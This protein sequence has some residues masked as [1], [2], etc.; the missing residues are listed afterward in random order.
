M[1]TIFLYPLKV[2]ICSAIL[3]IYY[4]FALRNK[5]FH[6]YNRFY[7]LF[8][9][10]VSLLLPILKLNWFYIPVENNN[11]A[12]WLQ[13]ITISANDTQQG[14]AVKY[15][16]VETISISLFILLSLTFL[17]IFLL[18]II[19]I[20]SIKKNYSVQKMGD[21]DFIN[22]EIQQAPF[23]F[24][25]ML[26]WRNDISLDS[27]AGRQIFKHELSHI[28]EKHTWDK[29]FVQS[30]NCFYWYNPFFYFMRKELFLV[31]E[32]I[33]DER[34]V[35]DEGTAAFAEMLLQANF[36]PN[37]FSP[38]QSFFY[39][40][41]KRR[42]I[43]LTTS[44]NPRYSYLRRLLALP[45]LA[46]IVLLFAFYTNKND[47]TA[48]TSAKVKTA[49]A[50]ITDTIPVYGSY[51]GKK[52]YG[53]KVLTAQSQVE[54]KFQDNTTKILSME[55]AKKLD[56]KIPPPPPPPPPSA[57]N[58]ITIT[59]DTLHFDGDSK[60]TVTLDNK[61]E[62]KGDFH[63]LYVLN[64]KIIS[65]EEM[66]NST[67][68]INSINVIKGDAATDKYGDNGKNGVIEI[69]AVNES[70]NAALSA[71]TVTNG[72]A[73]DQYDKEFTKAQIEPK[74]PGG[75][76]AWI[77]YLQRNLN[78]EVPYKAHAPNGTYTVVVSFLVD[79]EGTISEVKAL[80]DPGYGTAEEAVR[81]IKAGPMWTPAVQNGRNVIYRQKQSITFLVGN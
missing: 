41:I 46:T 60:S 61:I 77:K 11:A 36:Y 66:K 43:M 23:T 30:I 18:R 3:F 49:L 79:K 54:L 58:S 33:A 45:L 16:N 62:A 27:Q 67:L 15:L 55:E 80:N 70:V 68:H 19:K 63:P 14:F 78:S 28:N 53:V 65:E 6:Y 59:A 2:L 13:G 38:A 69:N 31:H 75:Q 39:S 29:L 34:S 8:A 51:Q 35:G 26:F 17:I 40:P 64:G 32:F 47:D 10:V 7:L 74:F 42:I 72:E 81:V 56:I 9:F 73:N 44:K 25:N 20:Y 76:Q 71:E 12:H 57:L 24:L 5:R 4:W 37:I 1:E 52:V 21:I 48:K 50:T 22:T